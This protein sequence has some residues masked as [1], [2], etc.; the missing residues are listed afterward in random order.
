MKHDIKC[1]LLGWVEENNF[2]YKVTK[3][4]EPIYELSWLNIP[5]RKRLTANYAAKSIVLHAPKIID[6]EI[7]VFTNK[8]LG[9]DWIRG[10]VCKEV[11]KVYTFT[12]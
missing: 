2:S 9:I 8:N 4:K 12:S 11:K 6:S 3:L 5:H 7:S 10:T 1:F